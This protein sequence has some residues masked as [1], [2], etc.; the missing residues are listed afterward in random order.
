MSSGRNTS[1][2]VGQEILSF[3]NMLNAVKTQSLLSY[4]FRERSQ[5]FPGILG[6]ALKE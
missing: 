5:Q 6:Y 4:A 1:P 2:D 3:M